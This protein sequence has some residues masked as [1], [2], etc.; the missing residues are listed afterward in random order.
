MSAAASMG[1][2][3]VAVVMYILSAVVSLGVAGIIKILFIA[4]KKQRKIAFSIVKMRR[5]RAAAA[6]GAI[7]TGS[8]R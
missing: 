6:E 2:I 5:K 4:I 1:P 7:K 3:Q 8:P